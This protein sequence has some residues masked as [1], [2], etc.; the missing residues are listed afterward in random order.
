MYSEIQ[1]LYGNKANE[2][3]IFF[4]PRRKGIIN[5]IST[6]KENQRIKA[7]KTKF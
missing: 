4:L 2:F 5:C 3:I 6:K 7:L 1:K